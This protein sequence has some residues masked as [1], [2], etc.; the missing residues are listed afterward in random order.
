MGEL[1]G[2]YGFLLF[3]LVSARTDFHGGCGR[4]LQ[5]PRREGAQ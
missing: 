5:E 3:G 2:R 4:V 1:R